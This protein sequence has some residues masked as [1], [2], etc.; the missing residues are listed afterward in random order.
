VTG[1]IKLTL[2]CRRARCRRALGCLLL[3]IIFY[4]AA[5]EAAHSHGSAAPHRS[6]VAALSDAGGSNSGTSPSHHQ[7]CLLC[8]FQQQLFNGLIHAPHFTLKPATQIAYVCT[9]TVL[10]SSTPTTRPSDRAP[11]LG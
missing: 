3:L 7:E 2:S 5:V 8:Q 9:L 11:P 1:R 4:G 10:H 6:R